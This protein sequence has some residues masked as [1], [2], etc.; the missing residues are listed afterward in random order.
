MSLAKRYNGSTF[1]RWIVSP[2]G[3]GFRLIAGSGFAVAGVLYRGTPAGKA[4][5]IC[6][7]LPLSAGGLDLCWISGA[8]GGPL[9]GAACRADGAS[10]RG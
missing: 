1:G 9:R 5:L 7:V 2:P 10:A 8:L 6:G 4:A 3:R